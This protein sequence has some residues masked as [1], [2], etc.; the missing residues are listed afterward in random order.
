MLDK[1]FIEEFGA[2]VKSW[3]IA[4]RYITRIWLFGSRIRG[5]SKIDSDLDIA[6]EYLPQQDESPVTRWAF[7]G[8]QWQTE[9]QAFTQY[10]IDLWRY[11]EKETPTIK[12]GLEE[13]SIKIYDRNEIAAHQD[14]GQAS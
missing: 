2:S 1:L 9:L 11:E 12:K 4:K 7:D 10:R 8:D 6:I 3:A 14:G 13:S 5:D